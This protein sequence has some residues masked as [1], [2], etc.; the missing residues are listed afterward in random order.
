MENLVNFN[1]ITRN[2]FSFDLSSSSAYLYL[3]GYSGDV[4]LQMGMNTAT[5]IIWLP[6]TDESDF[7]NVKLTSI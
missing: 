4:V 5:D 1:K 3:G 7:Y 2:I 6:V